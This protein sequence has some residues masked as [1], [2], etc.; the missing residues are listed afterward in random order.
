MA[1][2]KVKTLS[3][4]QVANFLQGPV[5]SVITEVGNS[6]K[7]KASTPVLRV[8]REY[9]PKRRGRVR[10]TSPKQEW[11]VKTFVLKRDSQ[12][13]I[14]PYKRTGRLARGW[15]YSGEKTAKGYLLVLRNTLD[16]ARYVYGISF[17]KTTNKQGFHNDTGWYSAK[18]RAGL[19]YDLQLKAIDEVLNGF[20]QS[21]RI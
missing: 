8:A 6:V 16:Y 19:L 10:W 15:V 1:T 17:D 5:E 12:G 18:D 13:N 11:Y 21:G 20:N 2:Y 3:K 14:I 4:T 7:H 9:P